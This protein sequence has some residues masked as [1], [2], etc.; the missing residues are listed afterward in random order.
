MGYGFDYGIVD[1]RY[2][3]IYLRHSP[4]SV[5][6]HGVGFGAAKRMFLFHIHWRERLNDKQ[7]PA[8]AKTM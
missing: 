8:R 4:V 7:W 1:T 6:R 5:P 3:Y 2:E